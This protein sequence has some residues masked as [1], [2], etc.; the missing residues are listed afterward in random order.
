MFDWNNPLLS[1]QSLSL[2]KMVTG[3]LQQEKKNKTQKMGLKFA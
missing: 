1:Y 2:A 3:R